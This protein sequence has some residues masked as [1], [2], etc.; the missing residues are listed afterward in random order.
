MDN[1]SFSRRWPSWVIVLA[2]IWLFVSPWVLGFTDQTTLMWSSY[3]SGAALFV[4]GLWSALSGSVVPSWLNVL[5]GAWLIASP[6]AL[7]SRIEGGFSGEYGNAL[8]S[9]IIVGAVAV[10]MASIALA[11][12]YMWLNSRATE[13][14]VYRR[15][16]GDCR[17]LGTC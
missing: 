14:T 13:P 1:M 5:A 4:F 6:F 10:V 9:T 16:Q 11:Y 12:K 17:E 7:S 2:G 15:S 3:I 8:W